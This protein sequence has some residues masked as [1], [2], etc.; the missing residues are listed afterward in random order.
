M[1]H[2]AP[3]FAR[4]LV[5]PKLPLQYARCRALLVSPLSLA[6][7]LP[8]L[9]AMCFFAI[10][11]TIMIAL[12]TRLL[13]ALCVLACVAVTL[14]PVAVALGIALALRTFP[15]ALGIAI[16]F[17]LPTLTVDAAP[18][19]DGLCHG[20]DAGAINDARRIH[21]ARWVGLRVRLWIPGGISGCVVITVVW[22]GNAAA[23]Q[24]RHSAQGQQAGG[25]GFKHGVVS[26]WRVKRGLQCR[27]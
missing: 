10:T 1:H 4:L 15:I 25:G 21:R 22:H 23:G 2:V 6:F 13:I 20:I 24:C 19:V 8:L 14:C 16:A 5:L 7:L 11:I 3:V 27:T 12:L 18:V 9:A 26:S 17:A